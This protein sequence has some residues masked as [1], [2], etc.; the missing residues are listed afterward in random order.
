MNTRAIIDVSDL[1]FS[2]DG[3]DGADGGTSDVRHPGQAVLQGLELEIPAGSITAILGPNGSGKTTLLH[4]ILGLLSPGRGTIRLAGR[5]Q[6]SYSRREMG[7][8]MALVPQSEAITFNFSVLEYVL[9]GR[10]PYLG[11]LEMPRPTDRQVAAAAL[12]MTGAG[13]LQDRPVSALSGGEHQLIILARALAQEPRILLLDEPTSHL[14]LGNQ[15]R[16]LRILRRLS[17]A[18][19]TVV[20]TTHDPNVAAAVA[21]TVVLMDRG[22]VFSAA[23]AASALT[24][25]NLSAVYG[26][27]VLVLQAQ[28]RLII[29]L[30]TFPKGTQQLPGATGSALQTPPPANSM[31]P[32][33]SGR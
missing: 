13:A 21:D 17:A 27:P 7:R 3:T 29:C 22:K 19:V 30:A 25:H 8:L 11:P 6:A 33:L 23:P 28:D 2:Y 14:D 15:E 18:G 20:L 12:E 9:M 31:P 5:P 26:V 32:Q 10:A 16:I 1:W 24:A 4:L